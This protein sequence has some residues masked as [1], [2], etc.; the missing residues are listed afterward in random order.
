MN[1]KR[2]GLLIVSVL[3]ILAGLVWISRPMWHWFFMSLYIYPV[4]WESLVISITIGAISY[5]VWFSQK[6]YETWDDFGGAKGRTIGIFLIVLIIVGIILGSFQLMYPQCY[7]AENLEVSEIAEL[8]DIDPSA[9]RIMPLAVSQRY[10]K[11][12]LQYPRFKLG[13]ADISFVNKTPCWIYGLIPDGVVNFFVLKDKGAVYVEMTTSE[14]NTK[15]IEQD[16]EIG[17]GMGISDWYKWKLYKEKY[18][19]YYEDPYFVSTENKLHIAVP[20][21]SYKYHWKFP[22]FYTVPKWTGTALID[23]E[24]KVEFLTPE[25]AKK[26]PVLRDQKL[27]PERL[28]RYYVN[29]F[30]Y[31]HGIKSKLFYHTNQLEIADVPGQQNEQPFL[32][33]TKEG[34]KWFIACEPYGEAHGI[35]KVFLIDARTGEI[36]FNEQPKAEALIGPVKACDYVRKENP[37]VDWSR[38]TPVEPIPVIIQG[39]LYWQIKVIPND[40]SGIAYTAMV[41][42]QTADVVE[43]K[44][45]KEIKRFIKGEYAVKAEIPAEIAKNITAIVIIREDDREIQRIELFQNQSV[46]VIPQIAS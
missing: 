23:S 7:L 45:D 28:T 17:E 39:K 13:T 41:D 9:I 18:W 29:S 1:D 11:D 5:I 21:I 14:K 2:K 3:V 20:I 4:I 40:A 6:E 10:A 34:M 38:M 46:V 12:A 16:M 33:V 25:E 15:I 31:T 36:Q 22:T 37:I 19:V 32:V 26:H 30:R 8:P 35:F 24:G 44:T 42:S 43:L 27:Y